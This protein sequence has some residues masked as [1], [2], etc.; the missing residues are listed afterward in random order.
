[1]LLQLLYIR[2]FLALFLKCPTTIFILTGLIPSVPGSSLFYMMQNLVLNNSKE[3]L[4]QGII[5]IEVILGIVSGM[6]FASVI[7]AIINANKK[8]KKLHTL[9]CMFSFSL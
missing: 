6:L 1:M 7:M 3:A 2:N 5:T 8:E 4:N 9:I